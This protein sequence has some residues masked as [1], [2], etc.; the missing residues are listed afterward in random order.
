MATLVLRT[1]KGSPLTNSEVDGNFSNINTEVGVVFDTANTINSNVGVLA[2]LATA[3]KSNL[4]A[5]INEIASESTSNVTITGGTVSGTVITNSTYQG[6]TIS[7]TYTEAKIATVSNSAPISAVVSGNTA[8]ISHLNSGVTAATYGNSTVIPVITVNATGHVTSVSNVNLS[9]S[10]GGGGSGLFNTAISAAGNIAVD[11]A[12]ANVYV[13]PSTAGKRYILHSIHVTNIDTVNPAEVSV[14][15]VGSTYS[16]IS[17]ANT[18]PIP[19]GTSVELLKKPKI[20]QPSDYVQLTAN[21]DSAV[22][23]T[24][25]I[26]EVT[27]TSH[28]GSGIDVTSA[29]TYTDLHTATGN[30]VLESILLSNDN[31]DLDVKARVVWTD[32]SDNIY[33]YFCFDL[34]IPADSTVEILEQ[35]KYLPNGY[36]V[37]VYANQANR[38]EATIA[39]RVI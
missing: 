8:T 37:R 35:P 31:L 7:I 33:G 39:G 36:K 20:L 18:L 11:T 24:A 32:G 25:T 21:I 5:A 19:V 29:A 23:A 30:S 12:G 17:L 15:V 6:N 28:F 38:L 16:S 13:A 27:G 2:N 14:Q 22:H 3:A 10:S 4:V 34:T 1:V 26:E 9:A